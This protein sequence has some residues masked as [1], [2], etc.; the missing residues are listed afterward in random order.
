MIQGTAITKLDKGFTFTTTGNMGAYLI[1]YDKGI[2]P[3]S[4]TEAETTV[5]GTTAAPQPTTSSG[6]GGNSGSD[7]DSPGP[8]KPTTAPTAPVS[9][10]ESLP[11]G[12]LVTPGN[13][14]EPISPTQPV[15]FPED[16]EQPA[17]PNYKNPP[18]GGGAVVK[19]EDGLYYH[20]SDDNV[21]LAYYS[22]IEDTWVPLGNFNPELAGLPK[23]G[24]LWQRTVYP[25]IMMI[26]VAGILMTVITVRRRRLE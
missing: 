11:P 4:T 13:P 1:A 3:P 12:E 10:S 16:S 14:L 19:G 25:A 2:T 5:P 22:V 15:V 26:L 6:N 20:I 18:G 7:N 24:E 17:T 21:P 8:T 23:T 9:P